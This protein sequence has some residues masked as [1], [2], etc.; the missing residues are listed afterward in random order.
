MAATPL[1]DPCWDRVVLGGDGTVIVGFHAA[2][3]SPCRLFRPLLDEL[4]D[5]LRGRATVLTFD[6]E[7]NPGAA[8]RYDVSSLP[9]LLVF[10]AGQLRARVVGT[11]SKERLLA[12]LLPYVPC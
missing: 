4:A 5:D 11:R 10:R 3:S 9:T 7:D 1:S 6:A 12:A 8:R 2:W